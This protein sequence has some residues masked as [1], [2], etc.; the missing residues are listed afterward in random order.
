[1][2][3]YTGKTAATRV[4]YG[5]PDTIRTCDRLVR[6]QIVSGCKRLIFEAK[7]KSRFYAIQWFMPQY[8]QSV[9][10]D[11][12]APWSAGIGP[13]SNWLKASRSNSP[14]ASSGAAFYAL[15]VP[16]NFSVHAPEAAYGVVRDFEWDTF[17][18]IRCPNFHPRIACH[19]PDNRT[20]TRKDS[21]AST[22]I[23]APAGY[24]IPT[25]W[26]ETS[27]TDTGGRLARPGMHLF[28]PHREGAI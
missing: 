20:G 25:E 15:A 19:R 14:Q 3:G 21:L 2:Y 24:A 6:S 18:T 16:F 1:M 26:V 17:C 22:P 28:P 7:V 5:A 8:Y 11:F 23:P 27:A 12:Y 13:M 9:A 4:E 10:A